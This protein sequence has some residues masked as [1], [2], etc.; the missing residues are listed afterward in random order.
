MT[1]PRAGAG[2]FLV[3]RAGGERYGLD[4]AA[5][6]EIV[7]VAPPR[8]VPARTA[9]LR[10][11]MPV[12]EHFCSLLHLGAL[13]AGGGMTPPAVTGDT[14][15]IV[16]TA[17]AR[18]ALEVDDVEAVV[19]RGAEYVGAAPAAWAS[20]VWR[21]GTELVTVLDLGVL[22]ERITEGGSGNDAG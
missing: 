7:D 12:R 19:D 8:P 18:V 22:A 11:V 20:G 5:V 9:A 1:A 16:E 6:R 21:V 15:V 4:L 17:H 2:R 14:A 3:V 13:L 10:G